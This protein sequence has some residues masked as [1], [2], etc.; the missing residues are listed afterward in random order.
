[1]GMSMETRIRAGAR[2]ALLL[3]AAVAASSCTPPDP[4]AILEPVEVVTGWY[5]AGILEDGKNKLVPSVSLK[6]RNKGDIGITTVQMNA[7][8]RRVGEQ[9]VWGEHYTWAVQR[10]ELSPGETTEPVVLRSTLGYT[11]TQARSTMLQHSEF[12]DAKVEL[13]LKKGSRAWTKFA[14]YPIERQVL[15]R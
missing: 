8:F 1:M 11:G 12:V 9:E 2:A 6:L 15:T 5:D 13:F 3:V 14:E 10:E 4:V 7:I